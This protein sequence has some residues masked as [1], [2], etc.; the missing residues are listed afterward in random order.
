MP[1]RMII[2]TANKVSR[3]R[4]GL[5]APCSMTAAMLATSMKVTDRVRS[6]VP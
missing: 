4:L 2:T 1:L 6:K 5:F 3:A